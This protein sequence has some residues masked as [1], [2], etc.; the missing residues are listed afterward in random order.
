MKRKT[1]NP[2]VLL[3]YLKKNK[4]PYKI[5]KTLYTM[6][7]ES[8]LGITK[9]ISNESSVPKNELFFINQLKKACEKIDY[10]TYGNI[11]SSDI[12]YFNLPE[13]V[14]TKKNCYEVD[15]SGAYWHFA[16]EFLPL[17]VYNA[18]LKVSK[19]TRLAALG[20]LAK[21]TS[22]IDFDGDGFIYR[23]TQTADTRNLFFYCA[24]KTSEIIHSIFQVCESPVF[25][26]VDAVFVA[27]KKDLDYIY[28]V[29]ELNGMGGKTFFCEKI[30][31]TDLAVN[32]YSK[33]HYKEKEPENEY[34]VFF[35]QKKNSSY[36]INKLLNENRKLY[37]GL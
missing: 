3:Q 27:N 6:E 31:S 24:K 20:S 2:F 14:F 33:Q 34:R 23:E 19:G 7:I 15:I 13:N 10:R 11:N 26:W 9:W 12:N 21:T 4:I 30:V 29:L 28:A 16:K 5:K 1:V 18:G 35:K 36:F 17:E 22:Y 25:F 8:K 37:T 32:V